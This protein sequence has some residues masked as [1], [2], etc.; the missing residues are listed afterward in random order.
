[1]KGETPVSA[2]WSRCSFWV[3]VELMQF[4]VQIGFFSFLQTLPYKTDSEILW[5]IL[6]AVILILLWK[7]PHNIY[8]AGWMISH[9]R[10][11]NVWDQEV[12]PGH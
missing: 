3:S 9:I 7:Q 2:K 4:V 8:H 1:M 11:P 5:L 12:N 6:A 10:E